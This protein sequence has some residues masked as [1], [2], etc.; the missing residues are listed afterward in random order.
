[1]TESS[2][3]THVTVAD[4]DGMVV[5]MT[6]TINAAFGAE[7][8]APGT[9]MLLNNTMAL[10]DPHPGRPNSVAGG[11]RMVKSMSPAIVVR[12]GRPVLALGTPGGVRI[13]HAVLQALLNVIDHGMSL[14]QAVEAPRVWTQGQQLEVEPAIPEPV[15]ADL[16]ARGHDV[17]GVDTVAGGMNGIAW[18][19][20]G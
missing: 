12:D 7:V 11:R 13:F 10:L 3:T 5:A 17:V 1:S 8:D 2:T 15:R 14:Q 16:R 19:R 18:G 4:A 9:G 20:D 6:Q